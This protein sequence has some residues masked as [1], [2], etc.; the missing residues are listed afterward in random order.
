VNERRYRILIIASALGVLIGTLR[1]RQQLRDVA[2][3]GETLGD[4]VGTRWQ[5]IDATEAR[6]VAL[7]NKLMWLTVAL[8]L[9][10]LATL[11]VSIVTLV[12]A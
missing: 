3:V 9:I 10:A 11:V 6:L 7:T 4:M 5:E 8:S 1:N 2:D 12:M